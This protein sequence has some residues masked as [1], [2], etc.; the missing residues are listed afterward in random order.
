MLTKVAFGNSILSGVWNFDQLNS[1]R[2]QFLVIRNLVFGLA[3]QATFV[4]S[5]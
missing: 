1:L 4:K 2:S 3:F 5:S